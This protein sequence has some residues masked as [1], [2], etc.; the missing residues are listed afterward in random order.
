MSINCSFEPEILGTGGALRRASWFIQKNPIWVLN[1]DVVA[2]LDPEP[3]IQSLSNP[4]HIAALWM[5]P[6]AGP[7]SVDCEKGRVIR[8]RAREAGASGTATFSGLHLLRPEV[9]TWLPRQEIFSSII[10]AY[11]SAMRA[12]RTIGAVQVAGS[13]WADVGTPEQYLDAHRAWTSHRSSRKNFRIID[14]SADVDAGATLSD[15]VVMSGAV[16][17]KRAVVHNAIVAPNTNVLHQG[18]RLLCPVADLCTDEELNHLRKI[19]LDDPSSC[20]ECLSPRGSARQFIRVSRGR[21]AVMLIRFDPARK[22]N[23]LYANQARILHKAGLPV[24]QVLAEGKNKPFMVI[25]DL[26]RITLQDKVRGASQSV[27][28]T[29]YRQAVSVMNEFHVR[30]LPLSKKG[31]LPL[32]PPFT[33]RL[34]GA[35]HELFANEFLKRFDASQPHKKLL[36]ELGSVAQSLTRLP[37][38]VV[39]R[40]YQSTNLM[41]NRRQLW[42]IDFQGMRKGPAVHDLAS[43]LFDPYVNIS[44][45]AVKTLI[46]HYASLVP[47][48]SFNPDDVYLA[49]IQRLVQALG[50]Y[51]RLS[52]LPG[53]E[54]FLEHVPCALARLSIAART[55]QKTSG[56][57]DWAATMRNQWT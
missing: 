7:R 41:V 55:L 25:E 46:L 3:L 12:G 29:W 50:A 47:E 16:I 48:R 30:A 20:A 54:H 18:S 56:I 21:H 10:A 52:R 17:G 38:V 11:E 6:D 8:F 32:M 9:L 53:C 4:K 35:E 33:K 13:F 24:F 5:V 31:R 15:T 36:L 22:E 19:G 26:G 44:Q 14:P 57:A 43:L 2:D 28:L 23:A 51:G 39:H 40:D 42:L 37:R 34:F 49:G 27:R 45:K 1:A